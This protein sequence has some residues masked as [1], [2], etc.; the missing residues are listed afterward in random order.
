M[1]YRI[2]R[3]VD[4]PIINF[5][6]QFIADLSE[7]ADTNMKKVVLDGPVRSAPGTSSPPIRTEIK[8]LDS[9]MARTFR[10]RFTKIIL[11]DDVRM[12]INK[13]LILIGV[14]SGD[15]I[16]T[17]LPNRLKLATYFEYVPVSLG[18]QEM[19]FKYVVGDERPALIKLK[20]SVTQPNINT[21]KYPVDK[22]WR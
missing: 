7:R 5:I 11:R 22:T 15:I 10:Q 3:F 1:D 12:E 13:K 21:G 9:I 19:F 6:H 16:V 8:L 14:Y 4:R 20:L 17:Q 18:E 2:V